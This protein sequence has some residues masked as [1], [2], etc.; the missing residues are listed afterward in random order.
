MA[1]AVSRVLAGLLCLA[2]LSFS[3]FTQVMVGKLSDEWE[4]EPGHVYQGT[5]DI[6][7]LQ[8]A[9]ATVRIYQTDYLFFSDGASQ[10]PAPGT[11]ERS[12]AGWV[13]L[14][15]DSPYATIPGMSVL[16]VVYQVRVPDD[17]QLAGTYWSMV[18]V[19]PE[20]AVLAPE[21]G[22]G[23]QNI[24][25]YGIQIVTSIGRLGER[26]VTLLGSSVVT[27]LSGT[28]FFADLENTGEYWL[29]PVVSLEVFDQLGNSLG[30]IES[31]SGK[32]RIYPGCSVRHWIALPQLEPG[33]YPAI[34]LIDNLD[35]YLWGAQVTVNV[36]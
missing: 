36:K 14:E 11:L 21:Q 18:N 8:T 32:L 25:G 26:A 9:P 12:N 33:T 4:V 27:N 22:V 7:N 2:A 34:L 24:F 16:S 31:A 29:R 10:T 20:V 5:I 35:E 13:T 17:L 30:R 19:D 3:A 1:R 23:I 15:L 6:T 28:T